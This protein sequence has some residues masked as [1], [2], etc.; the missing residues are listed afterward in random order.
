MP[1]GAQRQQ[2][3]AQSFRHGA[4]E[5]GEETGALILIDQRDV[6]SVQTGPGH[7]ANIEGHGLLLVGGQ[8]GGLFLVHACH[9]RLAQLHEA[10]LL[11]RG[12]GVGHR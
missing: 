12:N 1:R 4:V 6:Q 2:V 11:A 5:R 10:L 3:A 7:H 9:Q 8:H